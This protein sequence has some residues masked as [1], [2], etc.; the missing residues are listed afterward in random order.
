[1]ASK[2][3]LQST[4]S[5][6]KASQ[7][8]PLLL[9]TANTL[10]CQCAAIRRH[11]GGMAAR[12]FVLA[13]VMKCWTRGD[14]CQR[15][16]LPRRCLHSGA[17]AGGNGDFAESG[18]TSCTVCFLA[19]ARRPRSLSSRCVIRLFNDSRCLWDGI[20]IKVSVAGVSVCV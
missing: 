6:S 15:Q 13:H 1:M 16:R 2:E 8:R 17:G 10:S 12:P 9:A 20:F 4:Q 7:F 14:M 3:E 18:F 19:F 11:L 5:I